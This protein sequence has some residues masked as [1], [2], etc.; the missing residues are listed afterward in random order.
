MRLPSLASQS[1]D[2]RD[3]RAPGPLASP[4][5]QGTSPKQ[6][7]A[8][9]RGRRQGRGGLSS[10]LQEAD[11]HGEYWNALQFEIDVGKYDLAAVHLR[12]LLNFKPTDADLVKLADE[13]G[14]AAFL[15]LRNIPQMVRMIPKSTRKRSTTSSSSSST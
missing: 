13:V 15:R 10:I 12:N 11:Q 8:A 9:R 1:G 7:A 3:D 5:G 6:P 2:V 4:G 14:V